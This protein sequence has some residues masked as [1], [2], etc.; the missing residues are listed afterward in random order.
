MN[1]DAALISA[2][3]GVFAQEAEALGL[4]TL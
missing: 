1:E 3:N 4:L 2:L